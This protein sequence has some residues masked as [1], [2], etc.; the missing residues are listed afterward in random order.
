M[1]RPAPTISRR[2]QRPGS[3]WPIAHDS[4]EIELRGREAPQPAAAQGGG[5]RDAHQQ[6]ARVQ[7]HRGG[8][9]GG[10][11][12]ARAEQRGGG[13]LGGAG[14][15]G[16]GHHERGQRRRSPAEVASTPKVRPSNTLATAS[17][18]TRRAPSA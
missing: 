17:G 12:A 1:A 7:Q 3:T 2:S 9:G 13:E 11:A 18:A 15:G 14:E 10:R 6:R 8:H 5:D 16:G 4:S